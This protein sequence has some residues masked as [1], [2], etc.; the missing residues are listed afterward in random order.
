VDDGQDGNDED[1]SGAGSADSPEKQLGI[2]IAYVPH[3]FLLSG[4]SETKAYLALNHVPNLLS[5]IIRKCDL[6]SNYR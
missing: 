2:C 1:G 6:I 3:S 4:Y 5:M